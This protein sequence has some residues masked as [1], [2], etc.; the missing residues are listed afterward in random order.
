MAVPAAVVVHADDGVAI[1][2]SDTSN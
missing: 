1:D 2:D